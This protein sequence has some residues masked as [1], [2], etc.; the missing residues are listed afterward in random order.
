MTFF[1]RII[2]EGNAP[3]LLSGFN[4][5]SKEQQAAVDLKGLLRELRNFHLKVGG[6]CTGLALILYAV[7]YKD[8]AM[9][10]V[11]LGPMLGYIY[12]IPRMQ[13]YYG[14]SNSDIQK[15]AKIGLWLLVIVL[16]AV[17]G[18]LVYGYQDNTLEISSDK[19]KFSGMYGLEIS[20]KEAPQLFEINRLPPLTK[21]INGFATQHM[22][23]GK[24][25]VKSGKKVHL[26]L[27]ELQGPYLEIKRDRKPSVYFSLG[28]NATTQLNRL[29][30]LGWS[31]TRPS[32]N[33]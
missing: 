13:N 10:T 25:R 2:T 12:L 30:Q 26:L 5:M 24:F 15:Q 3:Q 27:N 19:L 11:S 8:A 16:V 4:T 32:I 1:P 23:K 9:F 31:V 7:N 29:R 18:L 21:R 22:R 20:K 6:F 28:K 17:A 14:K 33:D